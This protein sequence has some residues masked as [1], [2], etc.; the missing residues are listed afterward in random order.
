MTTPG[1]T[2]SNLDPEQL[3]NLNPETG[4]IPKQRLTSAAR[5]RAIYYQ[6]VKNYTLRSQ[7]NQLVQG[8]IDGNQPYSS[9]ALAKAKQSWRSNFNSGEPYAALEVALTAFYDLET[10]VN[11]LAT[12]EVQSDHPDAMTW[13]E[14]IQAEFDKLMRS[15][16]SRDYKRQLS[17]HDMVVFGSGPMVWD[18]EW[19]WKARPVMHRF[20]RLPYQAPASVKEWDRCSI[21]YEF[22]VGQLYAFISD[23]EAAKNAGWDVES[24]KNAIMFAGQGINWDVGPWDQWETIQRL[25]RDNEIWWSERANRVRVCRHLIKEFKQEDG[26][27]G[28][29]DQWVSV[30]GTEDVFLFEKIRRFENM[31][32]VVAPFFYDRGTGDAHSIKGLGVKQYGLQ[33]ASMRLLNGAVDATHANG[34]AMFQSASAATKPNLEIVHMGPFTILPNGWNYIQRQIQG[35][36]EPFFEARQILRNT[37]QGNLS[38]YR[39]NKDDG[40][41]NPATATQVTLDAQQAA[42]LNKTAI[43][44]FFIQLD[45]YYAEM[46]RRATAQQVAAMGES[47]AQ[48]LQFQIRCFTKGVP[49]EAFKVC[50]VKATRT[51]GQGSSWLRTTVLTGLKQMIGGELPPDGQQSLTRDIIAATVGQSLVQ[52]YYPQPEQQ[53]GKMENVHDAALEN[54]VIESG[55]S[56]PI[57]GMEMH[58]VHLEVH[59]Q[60]ADSAM[61]SLPQGADPMHVYKAMEALGPHMHLHI[62]ALAKNPAKIGLAKHYQQIFQKF[63]KAVD[64]LGRHIQ[65]QAK[66]QQEQQ[67][68]TQKVMNDQ[69]LAQAETMAEIQRKQQEHDAKLAMKEETHKQQM[70]I[71]DATAATNITVTKAQAASR[72]KTE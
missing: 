35:S 30:Q 22:T 61:G 32:Q 15:D 47:A 24:V 41:G 50:R 29:S 14:I 72:Q 8:L 69:Q 65:E 33:L 56:V 62:D 11:T 27:E 19:D 12:V 36:A 23:P 42:L 68:K 21:E 40:A 55:A 17:Q 63:A 45:Q 44:R 5:G 53:R 18:D 57:T 38:Q 60:F 31:A 4:K 16:E 3:E 58:E 2:S 6:D 28:I 43:N 26:N 25:A 34:T 10:E 59:S 9:A 71:R 48:A 46:F 52:R 51:V 67:A 54:G 70:A 64:D 13:S 66:Q 7:K 39:Q 37:I 1:P 20:L 49:Q